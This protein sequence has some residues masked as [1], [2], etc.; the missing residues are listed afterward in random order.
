[1]GRGSLQSRSVGGGEGDENNEL[2][3]SLTKAST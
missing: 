3:N 2:I 1:M